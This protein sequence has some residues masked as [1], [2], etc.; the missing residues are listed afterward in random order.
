MVP[1]CI[2]SVEEFWRASGGRSA[3]LRWWSRGIACVTV[4]GG[5]NCGSSPP[6]T[7]GR[8]TGRSRSLRCSALRSRTGGPITAAE[9]AGAPPTSTPPPNPRPECHTRTGA[10]LS[11]GYR[12]LIGRA[13]LRTGPVWAIMCRYHP[14]RVGGWVRGPLLRASAFLR[15]PRLRPSWRATR[16]VGESVRAGRVVHFSLLV[17]SVSNLK[18]LVSIGT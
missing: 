17:G 5:P 11:R 1:P 16:W 14:G 10:H 3:L 9:I 18:I 7:P 2:R 8:S 12:N 6:A 13:N 15:S 4:T